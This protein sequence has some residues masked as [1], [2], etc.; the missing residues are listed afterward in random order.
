MNDINYPSNNKEENTEL[1][2]TSLLNNMINKVLLIRKKHLAKLN[3]ERVRQ[4][5]HRKQEAN[6]TE[7]IRQVRQQRRNYRQKRR[8]DNANIK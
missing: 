3:R 2:I 5:R 1:I 7:Y 8:L 6:R 4:C